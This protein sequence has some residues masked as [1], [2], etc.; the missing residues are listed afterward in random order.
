LLIKLPSGGMLLAF[1]SLTNR[2][3]TVE[4]TTNL[5]SPIWLAAQPLTVT[6]ANYTYWIDYGPPETVSHPTNTPVRFYRVFLNP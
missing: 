6:P 3:Y 4:Y 2:T 1:P 5:L